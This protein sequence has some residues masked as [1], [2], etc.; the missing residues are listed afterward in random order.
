VAIEMTEHHTIVVKNAE[1]AMLAHIG[2]IKSR[3]KSDGIVMVRT[4][5]GFDIFYDSGNP[6]DNN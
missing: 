5:Q 2:K 3:M 6:D 4:E 1:A